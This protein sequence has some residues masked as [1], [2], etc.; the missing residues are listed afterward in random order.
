MT[1]TVQSDGNNQ[2]RHNGRAVLSHMTADATVSSGLF[3]VVEEM[4]AFEKG[5]TQSPTAKSSYSHL[6]VPHVSKSASAS[7]ADLQQLVQSGSESVL[8]AP[9][10]MPVFT[11]SS[12]DETPADEEEVRRMI[13][14][15]EAIVLLDGDSDLEVETEVPS[16]E[17]LVSWEV[18]KHLKPKEKKRQE[19]INGN[20]KYNLKTIINV[21]L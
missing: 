11:S 16:L 14:G 10:P 7:A 6:S 18:L 12:L 8:A 1:I 20:T 9:S 3:G 19:V 17:S 5:V 4:G 13:E 2:I 15:A 21:A